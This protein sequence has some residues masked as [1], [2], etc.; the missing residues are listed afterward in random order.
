MNKEIEVIKKND[1]WELASLPHGQKPIGVECIYK[2][3]KNAKWK[4][5]TLE[6]KVNSKMMQSTI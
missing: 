2:E 6:G 4:N 5:R 3:K 1:T